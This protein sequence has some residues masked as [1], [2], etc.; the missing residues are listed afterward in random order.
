LFDGDTVAVGYVFTGGVVTAGADAT[1]FEGEANGLGWSDSITRIFS[2]PG[3]L[4]NLKFPL[5]GI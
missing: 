4:S 1:W 5:G 2:V 3:L